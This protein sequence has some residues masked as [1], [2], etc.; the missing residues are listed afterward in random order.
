MTCGN[1]SDSHISQA[2]GSTP[3]EYWCDCENVFSQ[4]SK[5]PP[6]AG[7]GHR[8]RSSLNSLG[9]ANSAN[10]S[11]DEI[12]ISTTTIPNVITGVKDSAVK[13]AGVEIK[14]DLISL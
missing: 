6:S 9:S 14:N 4:Q 3:H 7:T 8:R 12:Q 13:L 1:P 2:M 5:F 11:S 10:S